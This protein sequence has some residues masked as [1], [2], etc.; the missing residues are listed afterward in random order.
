MRRLTVERYDSSKADIDLCMQCEVIW[1]D[2]AESTQMSGAAVI[3]LFKVMNEHSDL[4]R[5]PLSSRLA[6]PRCEG[7]LEQTQDICKAGRI[8]Y[9]RCTQHHGRLTPFFQ[10]LREKQFIRSLSPVEIGNL[11][12]QTRQI[13]CSGCGAALDLEKETCCPYCGSPVSVLDADAVK[14]A[15]ETWSQAEERRHHRS[16]D[17]IAQAV[18]DVAGAQYKLEQMKE[19]PY[20]FR[21]RG[22]EGGVDLLQVGIGALAGLFVLWE[23][24]N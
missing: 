12:V 17:A 2:Q 23:A 7:S 8:S 14:K 24:G 18:V 22:T 4:Q 19:H 20:L 15:L 21:D 16:P 11:K 5:L 3:E 6:C 1:F 13:R 10:F 9:F